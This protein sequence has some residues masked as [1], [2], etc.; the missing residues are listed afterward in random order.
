MTNYTQED[1]VKIRKAILELAAGARV[2]RVSLADKNIEYAQA[3][4]DKLEKL[5]IKINSEL[6]ASTRKGRIYKVKTSK[7]F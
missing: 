5:E 3:D 2:V 1:L 6:T 7:G 4:L